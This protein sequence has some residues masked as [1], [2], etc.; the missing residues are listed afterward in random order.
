MVLLMAAMVAFNDKN[1]KYAWELKRVLRT[2]APPIIPFVTLISHRQRL[3]VNHTKSITEKDEPTKY[4]NK[5][6]L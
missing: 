1:Q 2:H 6:G 3:R 5:N 4:A